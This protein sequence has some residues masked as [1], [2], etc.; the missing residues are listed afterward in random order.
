MVEWDQVT[1]DCWLDG[2]DL[3]E[4]R[5]EKSDANSVAHWRYGAT[6]THVVYI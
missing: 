6:T 4:G 5:K 1:N 2:N 3:V